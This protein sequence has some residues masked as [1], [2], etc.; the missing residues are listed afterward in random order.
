VK[1]KFI[2]ALLF[3]FIS[4]SKKESVNIYK[5]NQYLNLNEKDKIIGESVWATSCFRC[6]M[7]GSNG[8]NALDDKEYWGK[9]AEK[10][11]EDLFKSVW[12]G[13]YGEEGAM[14]PKGLCPSCSEDQIEK[15]IL[16]LFK[17]T[18]LNEPADSL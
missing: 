8:A 13:K 7:Y 1:K 15:S 12:E 9:T 2:L 5:T 17:L 14:P 16:Y 11:L 10:G 3:F 18:E 4:C 6:H